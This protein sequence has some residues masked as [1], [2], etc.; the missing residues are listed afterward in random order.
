MEKFGKSQPVKR[1]EDVRFLTGKGRYVDDTAPAGA[2]H[3]Y[4]VRS[5]QAHG[6][7]TALNLDEARTAP[8]VHMVLSQ[9]DLEAAGIEANIDAT[10]M[11][12]RDGTTG[13]GP[14]RPFL[15]KGKVRHVGEAMVCVIADSLEAAKDAGELIWAD[16]DDLPAKVD[17]ARGGE[18]LHAEAPDNLAFDW[19]LGDEDA[20]EKAFAEAAHVVSLNV[21]DNRIIVNSMEP[22]EC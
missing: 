10:L 2:P 6:T 18:T 13:A 8:G 22:R 11:K 7:I 3:A 15:A 5:S 1:M 16:I 4:F 21:A 19:G 12:N 14:E 20:T 9:A 17:I